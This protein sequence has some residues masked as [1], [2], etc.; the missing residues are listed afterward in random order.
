MIQWATGPPPLPLPSILPGSKSL[1]C[2]CLPMQVGDEAEVGGKGGPRGKAAQMAEQAEED[3]ERFMQVRRVLD[4]CLAGC[5][6][7]L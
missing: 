5:P 1:A 2:L 7:R 3:R 4:G 6:V